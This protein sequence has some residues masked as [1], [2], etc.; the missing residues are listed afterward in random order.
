MATDHHDPLDR[1]LADAIATLR[2]TPPAED[3]WAGIAPQLTPRHPAGTFLLRWPTAIAAG[4][5][6]A[7]ASIGGTL[8]LLRSGAVVPPTAPAGE[9]TP[10]APA[11]TIVAA[12]TPADQ[13]LQQAISQLEARLTSTEATIDPATREGIR[14][15]LAALDRA[16][17]DAATLQRATPD[18]PRSAQY[19]TSALQKKLDVLRTVTRRTTIRT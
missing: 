18:D 9:A 12:H 17:A 2:D 16:I 5:V 15:S 19:L 6:I 3:L 13:A 4:L 8:L 7:S 1:R 14:A 10:V 11:T